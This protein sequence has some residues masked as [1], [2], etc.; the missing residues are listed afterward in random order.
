MS[1]GSLL[2]QPQRLP[3]LANA[4]PAD[5]GIGDLA[6]LGIG[7]AIDTL[8]GGHILE[9]FEAAGE[10]ASARFLAQAEHGLDHARQR[11][12]RRSRRRSPPS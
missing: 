7:I 3:R 9:A 6:K 8:K 12:R 11:C 10:A 2:T 1:V 5:A 4:T